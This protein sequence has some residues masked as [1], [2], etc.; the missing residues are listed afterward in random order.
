MA[1]PTTWRSSSE[2]VPQSGNRRSSS[3]L[4]FDIATPPLAR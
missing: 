4:S 2:K 1:S 3:V